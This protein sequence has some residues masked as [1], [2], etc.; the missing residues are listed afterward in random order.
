MSLDY[1]ILG[2][3]NSAPLSGYDLKKQFDNSIQHFWTADQSQ[4]YRVLAKLRKKEYVTQEL[5]EQ[6]DRPDRKVYHITP[7]GRQ[8]LIDW[9][10]SDVSFPPMRYGP[11]IQIFFGADLSNEELLMIFKK[12]S[13]K[14]RKKL[15][16]LEQSLNQEISL[17]ENEMPRAVYLHNLTLEASKKQIQTR[18]AFA[19]EVIQRIENGEIPEK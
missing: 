2:F 15:K 13:M 11:M 5:I 4:I 18:L 3:L 9:L 7:A 16:M 10:K 17:F 19:K 6:H 8:A 12:Q 14:M 1:A